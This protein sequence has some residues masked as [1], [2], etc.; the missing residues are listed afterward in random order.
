M[1][2]TNIPL[3]CFCCLVAF[4]YPLKSTGQ[5]KPAALAPKLAKDL[6][7]IR[8]AA[9]SDD[10]AYRQV[11]HLTETIGPRPVGSPQ[12]N[13]AVEYVAGQLR[14]LGLDVRLEEVR[15]RRWVRG[16]ETA[17]LVDYPGHA[18]GATQK[19]VVTALGGNAATS[20]DGITAEVVVVRSFAELDALGSAGVNGKI[21]L[22]NV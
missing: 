4:C 15:A 1:T 12:I 14:E 16:L 19:V 20:N 22:F 21:V 3:I 11:S 13:A 17:E 10:Y 6:A 7:A 9:M 8:D 2:R 18:N 5:A